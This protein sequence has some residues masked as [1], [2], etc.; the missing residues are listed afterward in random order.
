MVQTKDNVS[1]DV[2]SVICWHVISPYRAA[3]GINDVRTALVERARKSI[4]LSTRSQADEQKPPFDKLSVVEF[5]SPSSLTERVSPRKSP[6]SY[7]SFNYLFNQ[8]D[9][10][11]EATAEKWGVAIESILLKDIN[12]SVELQQSLSSA[13]TQKRIGES[14]VIA[15]RAE[16]DA[17]KLMRQAADVRSILPF[18]L[19]RY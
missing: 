6:R 1:V 8:A 13:A 4:E 19:S 17:A 3:F 5:S 16:V 15:A 18:V 9:D 2:D 7:V 12:F 14:K 10:Q 11:I